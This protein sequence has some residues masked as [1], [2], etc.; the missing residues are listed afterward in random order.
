MPARVTVLETRC[1]SYEALQYNHSLLCVVGEWFDA[2]LLAPLWV[3]VDAPAHACPSIA[4][5]SGSNKQRPCPPSW[6]PRQVHYL[7]YTS[8]VLGCTRAE[9]PAPVLFLVARQSVF[10][11]DNCSASGTRG[12]RHPWDGRADARIVGEEIESWST[13]NNG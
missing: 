12:A 6:P 13:P 11:H 5:E 4:T 8:P 7:Y 1:R 10:A 3:R 9:V 2:N